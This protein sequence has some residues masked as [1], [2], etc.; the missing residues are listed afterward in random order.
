MGSAS[1]KEKLESEMMMLKLERVDIIQE[2]EERLKDLEKMTGE[3]IVRKPIPDYL[4]RDNPDA[5][6]MAGPAKKRRNEDEEDEEEEERP[7]KG[8]KQP[9][10]KGRKEESESASEEES[11]SGSEEPSDEEE[12]SEESGSG[13][14]ED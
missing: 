1:V 12:G 2:R 8:K 6:A 4:V 9:A 3:Q 13:S 11:G 5:G 10:K 7:K 14:E